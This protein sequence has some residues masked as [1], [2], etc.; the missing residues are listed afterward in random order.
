MAQYSTNSSALPILIV[1][2][3]YGV[4][5]ALAPDL[6]SVLLTFP[7]FAFVV[8]NIARATNP[9]IAPDDMLWLIVFMYFCIH[10]MQVMLGDSLVPKNSYGA[11][12]MYYFNNEA[13][14]AFGVIYIFILTF[15]AVRPLTRA[16]LSAK[17]AKRGIDRYL[18]MIAAVSFVMFIA[19]SGGL[20]NVLS[21]RYAQDRTD[22][23]AAAVF[24]LAILSIATLL[25]AADIRSKSGIRLSHPQA[26]FL[27]LQFAMLLVCK[28]PLNSARFYLLIIWVPIIL[29][30]L[31]GRIGRTLFY[32]LSLVGIFILF[33][34]LSFTTRFGF[35]SSNFRTVNSIEFDPITLQSV[36]I[37]KVLTHTIQYTSEHGYSLGAKTASIVFW[38]I[39]R[40]IWPDKPGVAALDI[41]G[42]LYQ[43]GATGT[44]NLSMFVAGN[45]YM[46]FGFPAVL[47]GGLIVGVLYYRFT[48]SG[49][50]FAGQDLRSYIWIAALPIL[51][52]GDLGAT[53]GLFM[54]EL[55]AL[56][57]LTRMLSRRPVPSDS[58]IAVGRMELAR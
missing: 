57:V 19:F 17:E 46:D 47:V 35:N 40:A 29:V 32:T 26:L 51:I 8:W 15:S 12:Q 6:Q 53:I 25:Q 36:D 41:G 10:P 39:P 31:R 56:A 55:I 20:G 1:C 45:L 5:A 23:S 13:Y 30:M 4:N 34:I 2:A 11:R 37:F 24:P 7:L 21:P 28:N 14:F 38:F 54:S 43:L 48:R 49:T 33:P 44:D 50:T 9:Y 52:R 16:R 27:A 3:L 22:T 58:S 42:E 18:F